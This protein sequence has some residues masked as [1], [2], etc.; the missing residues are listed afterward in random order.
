MREQALQDLVGDG[1]FVKSVSND[2]NTITFTFTDG[3]TQPITL[4]DEKGSVVTVEDGVLCIDGE[5]TEIKVAGSGEAGE[6]HKDQIIIENNM[7]SVLQENGEYKS[8]GVPVSGVTV[9]G[10]QAEGFVF[11]IYDAD[12]RIDVAPLPFFIAG[13]LR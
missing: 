7:W 10:S 4:T 13:R 6:E 2:G 5:P 11:T 1:K 9:S 8:T 3:T 12:C